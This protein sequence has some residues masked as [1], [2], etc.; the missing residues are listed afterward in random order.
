M[1]ESLSRSLKQVTLIPSSF[2]ANCL[3]RNRKG[4][5]QPLT[6]SE[7]DPSSCWVDKA[8]SGYGLHVRMCGR[9]YIPRLR[10]ASGF[11]ELCYHPYF[12]NTDFPYVL[13]LSEHPDVSFLTIVFPLTCLS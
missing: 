1:S 8:K 5:I 7:L 11:P 13:Q 6:T 9:S 2:D 10:M 12:Q 4:K 3:Q